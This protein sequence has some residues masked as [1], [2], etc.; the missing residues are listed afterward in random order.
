MKEC[1]HAGEPN[2]RTRPASRMG[3]HLGRSPDLRVEA[4]VGP[5][6]GGCPSGCA[7][8]A[9][10]LQ[11]RGQ[12][13]VCTAFPFNRANPDQSESPIRC[14]Q[15]AHNGGVL[16]CVNN[17]CIP[18]TGEG[19]AGLS[20]DAMGCAMGIYGRRV[21]NGSVFESQGWKTRGIRGEIGRNTGCFVVHRWDFRSSGK[22]SRDFVG[23]IWAR[24]SDVA[25]TTCG[26]NFCEQAP[27][28]PVFADFR[29]LYVVLYTPCGQDDVP[30]SRK[31]QL[32][33]MNSHGIPICTG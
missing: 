12:S 2:S 15:R 19:G 31:K 30:N 5:S 28:R 17:G 9:L 26:E 8:I 13:R 4:K 24:F 21:G 10:R 3:D 1:H 6:R 29:T 16:S 22:N 18:A 32:I 23:K 25:E 11:L 20:W 27:N 33:T 14:L 7:D